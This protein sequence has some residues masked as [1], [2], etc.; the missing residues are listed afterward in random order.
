MKIS[1]E[2]LTRWYHYWE[3]ATVQSEVHGMGAVP[4]EAVIAHKAS[5]HALEQAAKAV[6]SLRVGGTTEWSESHLAGVEALTQAA[7]AIRALKEEV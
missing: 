5:G 2:L 3:A 7:A 4:L 6:E 1:E